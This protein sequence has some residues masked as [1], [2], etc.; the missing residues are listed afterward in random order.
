MEYRHDMV[1]FLAMR[2]IGEAITKHSLISGV[3][4]RDPTKD[5]RIIEFCIHLPMEQFCKEGIDRRLVKIYLKDILPPHVIRFQ[6]Q[7]K[8]SADIRYRL[9]LNWESIRNEWIQIYETYEGSRYV[10]TVYAKRQLI[11]Q[12][13]INEYSDFDL[14]RHMYTLF[15]LKYEA[16]I[17]KTYPKNKKSNAKFYLR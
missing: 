16:Y 3:L 7:G 5:K 17:S 1:H 13:D 14:T 15:V 6:K 10:N 9:S 8:Q 4:Q 2:Q 11:N 12:P